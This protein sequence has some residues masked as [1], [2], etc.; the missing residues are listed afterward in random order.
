MFPRT[1]I[2]FVR[3]RPFVA[4]GVALTFTLAAA[5]YFLWHQRADAALRHEDVRRQGELMLRALSNRERI[6]ADL[7]AVTAAIDQIEHNLI[8]EQSME[9]NL[10]Y[11]YKLEK[12]ARVRLVRLNQL[13]ALPPAAG[14]PFKAVPFS[15]QL[16]GSYRDTMSFLRALETGPR[17]LRIRNC[18]Y[19]RSATDNSDLVLDLTVDVLAKP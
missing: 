18:T 11:F 6:D 14:S 5:N 16:A 7:A 13:A 3:A 2:H 19:E 4:G 15:M 1:L 10:G 12:P 17:I 9:V 8:D